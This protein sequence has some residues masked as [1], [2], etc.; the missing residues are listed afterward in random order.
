MFHLYSLV[1]RLLCI[2]GDQTIL[3]GFASGSVHGDRAVLHL[4]QRGR[5]LRQR[6]RGHLRSDLRLL[7]LDQEREHGLHDVGLPYGQCKAYKEGCSR[8]IVA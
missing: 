6:G 2:E 8:K 1:R 4:A 5:I 7:P 3:D